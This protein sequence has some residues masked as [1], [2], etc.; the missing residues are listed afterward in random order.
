MELE[1]T[2]QSDRKAQPDQEAACTPRSDKVRTGWLILVCVAAFATLLLLYDT[3]TENSARG[4]SSY[5]DQPTTPYSADF[6]SIMAQ[7]YGLAGC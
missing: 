6:W 3:I 5:S 1:L 7:Q 4:N 2:Q